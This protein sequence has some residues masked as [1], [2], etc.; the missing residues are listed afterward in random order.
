MIAGSLVA[1]AIMLTILYRAGA[2][3]STAI[4]GGTLLNMAVFAAMC[5]YV[6]QA[7]SFI[8]LRREHAHIERPYV[9]PFGVPGAVVTIVL[10]G[11]TILFQ[12]ADPVYRQ[13]VIGVA[14]WFA[15]GLL[16]F[17]IFG[18]RH[19]VLSPEEEFAVTKGVSDYKTH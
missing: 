8:L 15:I 16:Y 11:I 5:S 14:I 7:V 3:A 6:L 18:R 1:L 13:G 19:L 17:A 9:S 10:A 12:F 2:D 4:I